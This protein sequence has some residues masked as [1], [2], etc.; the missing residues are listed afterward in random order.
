MIRV[1]RSAKATTALT[2]LSSDAT[3]IPWL[4]I[5]VV[6]GTISNGVI[7]T[8]TFDAGMF[9]RAMVGLAMEDVFMTLNAETLTNKTAKTNNVV[10]I[11]LFKMLC[12]IA[13]WAKELLC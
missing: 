3:N 2:G 12:Y 1:A 10:E 6:A 5:S 8:E 7:A 4:T 9:D 11:I 13:Q